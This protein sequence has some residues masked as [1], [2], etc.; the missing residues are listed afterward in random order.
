MKRT[1]YNDGIEVDGSDLKNT[2]DTKIDE[3]L[4]TRKNTSRYGVIDGLKCSNSGNRIVIDTGR[5]LF[6]NGEIGV[7]STQIPNVSGSSFEKDV[8]TF[9]GLR[10]TEASSNPKPHEVDP[11]QKDTRATQV[12]VAELFVAGDSTSASRTLALQDAISSELNDGNFVLLA[13]FL[14]TGTGIEAVASQNTPLPRSK[15]GADPFRSTVLRKEQ[16]GGLVGVYYDPSHDQFPFASSEDHLHRSLIGRGIPSAGNPH[17]TTLTD[18]G[19]DAILEQTITKHQL[20]LHAN[21][22]IGLEP[23]DTDSDDPFGDF[24]PGSGTFA[25]S[26]NGDGTVTI[27]DISED[28][29]ILIQ[30]KVRT[31][32][33]I[34]SF[35]A[36]GTQ[37]LS[38][39]SPLS[40]AGQYY[41]VCRFASGDSQPVFV[42][43]S[44][45]DLDTRAVLSNGTKAWLNN[46]V[47]TDGERKYLVIGLVQWDGV[48]NFVNLNSNP[49]ITIPSPSGDVVYTN[50]PNLIG[51]AFFIPANKKALDLRRF[52]TVTNENTQKRTIRVD[53]IVPV[54]MTEDMFAVH[55][56]AKIVSGRPPVPWSSPYAHATP[57]P[58]TT[59]F[60]HLTDADALSLFSHRGFG[61]VQHG[62]SAHSGG[63]DGS[64]IPVDENSTNSGFQ[65]SVD[66]WK[67]QNLTMTIF[68]WADL[69]DIADGS[70]KG[71]GNAAAVFGGDPILQGAGSY[72]MYRRG[73]LK[74]FAAHIQKR[75]TSGSH[76]LTIRVGLRL[77]GAATG[78][79]TPY[80]VLYFGGVAFLSP[81]PLEVLSF[82]QGASANNI[83]CLN[84]SVI[85]DVPATPSTPVQIQMTREK[86]DS[87]DQWRNLTVTCEYHF[88]S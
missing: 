65:A 9:V 25:W 4:L 74:N 49:T 36:D 59:L 24:T 48:G 31:K 21:C 34:S 5:L 40:P 80:G 44:K 82:R 12:L 57:G 88:T 69:Q 61:G 32:G 87:N 30:G 62:L 7:L 39:V 85:L 63:V 55:A 79:A 46:A 78:E 6:S 18:I 70:E 42:I 26:A 16:I 1:L 10:L 68:R 43:V 15:G 45:T 41:I 19:G 72:V 23:G 83:V 13:E 81:T 54:V 76:S 22:I 8:S 11:I 33:E 37:R 27:H 20:D 56:G 51:H 47:D 29:S 52:G 84:T 53:R 38:F 60:K 77:I 17:A 66:K 75:P 28:E 86:N 14:G 64:G 50:D 71:M 73:V 58:D 2:E 67:Q 3:I 35:A